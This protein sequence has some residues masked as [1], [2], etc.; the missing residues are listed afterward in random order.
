MVVGSVIVGLLDMSEAYTIKVDAR[1]VNDLVKSLHKLDKETAKKIFNE[2]ADVVKKSLIT[3]LKN[4]TSHWKKSPK[5]RVI[6]KSSPDGFK[7][8]LFVQGDIFWYVSLGTKR[9]TIVPVQ[10]N[11]LRFTAGGKIIFTKRV[12]HP[13]SKAQNLDIELLEKAMDEIEPQIVKIV[14]KALYMAGI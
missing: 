11:A 1:Q 12:N 5:Y 14:E 10:A 13:G 2:I 3:Q 6:K 8:S 7:V 4:V 9:H